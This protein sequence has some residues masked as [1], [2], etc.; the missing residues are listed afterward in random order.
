M[1]GRFKSGVTLMGLREEENTVAVEESC[2][3][4]NSSTALFIS[5]SRVLELNCFLKVRYLFCS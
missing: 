5:S 4:G 3:L 1:A 2:V